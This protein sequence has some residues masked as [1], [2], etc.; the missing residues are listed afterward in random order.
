MHS[1]DTLTPSEAYDLVRENLS[2]ELLSPT[3]KRIASE[4]ANEF[5]GH[6]YAASEAVFHLLGGPNSDWVPQVLNHE[7]WPEGLEPGQT[8]WY[9]RNRVTGEV[10]DPTAEQFPVKPAYNAGKGCGFHC[11]PEQACPN[12]HRQGAGN[13]GGSSTMPLALI[14][15]MAELVDAAALNT[16]T[17]PGS[18]PGPRTS[19]MEERRE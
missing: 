12:T 7:R 4:T 5:S 11:P 15:G 3:W 17:F 14:A 19:V 16:V 9:L 18:N 10:M 1:I 13:S 6:C 8:H 2:D